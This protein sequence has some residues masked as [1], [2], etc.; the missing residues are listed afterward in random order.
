LQANNEPLLGH[1]INNQS[2]NISNSME[3]DERPDQL[4][5]WAWKERSGFLKY[6]AAFSNG[7]IEKWELWSVV[8]A[9]TTVSYYHT[10]EEDSSTPRGILELVTDQVV[11]TVVVPPEDAV[12]GNSL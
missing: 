12:R 8:V 1:I 11:A 9:G 3:T 2:N 5:L 6:G 4:R 7:R 10:G